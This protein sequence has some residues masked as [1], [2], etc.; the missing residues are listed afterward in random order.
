MQPLKEANIGKCL[1]LLEDFHEAVPFDEAEREL[2]E[3]KERARQALDQ[4]A[5]ILLEKADSS[6]QCDDKDPK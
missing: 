1:D 6:V 3:K 2:M 5:G 4:L